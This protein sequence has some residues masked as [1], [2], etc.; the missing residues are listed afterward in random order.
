MEREIVHIDEEKC[1]GCGLCVP[2]CHEGALQIIDGKAR[3]VSDLMSDGLGACLGH[4]PQDAISI[5]KREAQP[6]NETEVIALMIQKGR[7]TV[8]AH[9]K[10]LKDHNETVYLKEAVNYLLENEGKID[11]DVKEVIREVH[12]SGK[13]PQAVQQ[14]AQMHHHHGGGCPGS[15]SMDFGNID[16]DVPAAALGTQASQLKQWPV[17]MHLVQPNASYFQNSDLLLAAD[18][19]AF[20]MGNFHQDYLKGKSLAVLCPKLDQGIDSYI[21]KVRMMI[22]DAKVNTITVMMMQVP[23]CSGLLHIVKAAQANANRKVPVKSI[24]VGLQGELL[25]EEWV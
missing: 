9:M 19:V 10:H 7:N 1:N 5:E 8:L 4:C 12:N 15:K 14:V 18:C 24:I 17:Q 13:K 3:L 21:E 6:Y 22:D 25:K 20:S 11:F 2:E 16:P 23:C